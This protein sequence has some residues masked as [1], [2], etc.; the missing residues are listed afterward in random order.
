MSVDRYLIFERIL[1][2]SLQKYNKTVVKFPRSGRQKSPK[3]LLTKTTTS[4]LTLSKTHPNDLTC[5]GILGTGVKSETV[6]EALV[7]CLGLLTCRY[8]WNHEFC[9]Q[10]EYSEM[11]LLHQK[12]SWSC[13][14]P[15]LVPHTGRQLATNRLSQREGGRWRPRTEV[16]QG[17]QNTLTLWEG[18]ENLHLCG[19]DDWVDKAATGRAESGKGQ[20]SGRCLRIHFSHRPS[21]WLCSSKRYF[22]QDRSLWSEPSSSHLNL[23]P[24]NCFYFRYNSPKTGPIWLPG[25]WRRNFTVMIRGAEIQSLRTLVQLGFLFYQAVTWDPTVLDKDLFLSGRTENRLDYCP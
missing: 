23:Q 3:T 16:E 24:N 1:I 7:W 17:S 13:E 2:Y 22:L 8:G 15:L 21:E 4:H 25:S 20:R 12:Q 10:P 18:S 19:G 14:W 9:C 11:L 6:M 5:L